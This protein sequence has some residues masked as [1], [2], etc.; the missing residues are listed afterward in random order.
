MKLIVENWREYLI[1]LDQDTPG[2]ATDLEVA[3]VATI[4]GQVPSKFTNLANAIVTGLGVQSGEKLDTAPITEFWVKNGG[5]DNTTKADLQLDGVGVSLKYGQSQFMSGQGGETKATA[6]AALKNMKLDIGSASPEVQN[7]F[8]L[9]GNFMDKLFFERGVGELKKYIRKQQFDQYLESINLLQ[10]RMKFQTTVQA[11][12]DTI[13]KNNPEF[14][15]QFVFEAMTGREKFGP[16]NV[17]VAQKLLV[18]AGEKIVYRPQVTPQN[19]SK[20]MKY[21]TIDG[22]LAQYYMDKTKILVKF[23][24]DSEKIKG[25]KTGRKK[26]REVVGLMVGELPEFVASFKALQELRMSQAASTMEVPG[27]QDLGMALLAQVLSKHQITNLY[28]LMSVLA[29][30]VDEESSAEPRSLDFFQVD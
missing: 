29:L 23:K 19:F 30:T 5:K 1:E 16:S 22:A 25:I 18:V 15:K 20:F 9:L 6:A 24:T 3:I 10:E 21:K 27:T 7:L 28:D 11:A 26:G 8:F 2:R 12:F 17:G 13:A 4:N 14:K